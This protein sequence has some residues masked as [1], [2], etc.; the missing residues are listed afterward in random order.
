MLQLSES[1]ENVPI[2]SLQTGTKLASTIGII[3]DPDT[4]AIPAFYVEG[5][6]IDVQP[7]VVFVEDIR[8]VSDIG[9]IIDSSDRI[10]PLDGLVRLQKMIDADISLLDT[11]VIDQSGEKIGRI[12]DFSYESNLFVIQQILVRPP[13]LQRVLGDGRIIHRSHIVEVT[14]EK[15]IIDNSSALHTLREKG[16]ESTAFVNPFLAPDAEG[17]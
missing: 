8:E 12:E 3:I 11:L 10:M 1:L 4:L 6:G 14:K 16:D 5:P 7:S 15:V 13:L 2:L 9:F 17:R